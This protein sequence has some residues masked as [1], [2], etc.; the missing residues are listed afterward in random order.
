M[1]LIANSRKNSFDSFRSVVEFRQKMTLADKWHLAAKIWHGEHEYSIFK[2]LFLEELAISPK[3]S[4]IDA[5]CGTGFHTKMLLDIGFKDIS[6]SDY[7]FGNIE[8]VRCL[9]WYKESIMLFQADWKNLVDKTNKRY[10]VCLCLG[11][12]ITYFESWKENVTIHK[13]NRIDGLKQVFKSFKDI[14]KKGG[15]LVVG[16]SRHYSEEINSAEISF[17]DKYIN[18]IRHSLKWELSYDWE[19]R[20]KNWKC[21]INDEFSNDYSFI[22]QSHLITFDEFKVVAMEVFGNFQIFDVDPNYYD[23]FLVCK[24]KS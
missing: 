19:K 16:I 12:S 6:A 14:L 7:D 20:K 3:S 22:L 11:S 23:V 13:S 5:A 17:P 8:I 4:I 15:N 24:K 2:K 18:G 21:K 10:D 1:N 9:D